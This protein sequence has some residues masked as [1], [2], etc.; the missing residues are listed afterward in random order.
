M[1]LFNNKVSNYQTVDQTVDID[2]IYQFYKEKKDGCASNA[3]SDD[4]G[5]LPIISPDLKGDVIN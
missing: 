4:E 5:T 2:L 3:L 1:Q